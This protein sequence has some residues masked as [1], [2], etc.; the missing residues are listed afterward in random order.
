MFAVLRQGGRGRD[1]GQRGAVAV[2]AALITPLLIMLVFGIIEFGF[3]FKDWLAVTS[4]VRAGARIASAEPRVATY[5]TDAASQVAKEGAALSFDNNTV[6]WVYQ[7]GSNGFPVGQSGYSAC[8]TNCVKFTWNSA[9][10]SF[11]QQV[12]TDWPAANQNACE[13]DAAHDTVGVYLAV[14]DTGITGMFFSTKTLRS[15]TVMSLE[16][17]PATDLDANGCK[18]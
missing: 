9:S 14:K 12:G 1:R 16:P 6:L 18:P 13:G 7:A 10:K 17:V 3:L 8:T 4:A 2:E 5:A 15:R 11:V